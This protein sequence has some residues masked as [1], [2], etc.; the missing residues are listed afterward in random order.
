MI[1]YAAKRK[2]QI[3]LDIECFD[4]IDFDNID[5]ESVF[6]LEPDERVEVKVFEDNLS[7]VW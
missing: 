1:A 3:T 2:V 6:N 7:D 4:D 5:W